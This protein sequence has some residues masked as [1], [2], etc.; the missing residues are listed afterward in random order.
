M[1]PATPSRTLPK[2]NFQHSLASASA[3]GPVAAPAAADINESTPRWDQDAV[4]KARD[5]PSFSHPDHVIPPPSYDGVENLVVVCC[6]AIFHPDVLDPSF[7]LNS[8]HNE[9]N[10]YLAPFQES[11]AETGKPGEHET[12]L[13]HMSAGVET[14]TIGPWADSSVLVFSGGVTKAAL[15]PLSEAR[16]Y[17]HAALAEAMVNGYRDGGPVK[18]LF[19]QGRILLEEQATD[20]FQ[21]LLFS[22]LLFRQTTGFYPKQIRIITHAFKSKRF[23][24]LHAQAIRWPVDRVRVEGIDPIM[25]SAEYGDTLGGEQRFGYALW[26]GDPLGTGEILSMK[27]KQRGWVDEASQ[28]L[29]TGLEES[30]QELINGR[31]TESLPWIE[32]E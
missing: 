29:A 4:D 10:W 5:S 14:L 12:F 23:L 6:H 3:H 13:A 21:N 7:P 26:L 31:I 25:S 22:I 30:V 11:N 1:A 8:P 27:R 28:Q 19:D 2:S 17:Y 32:A 24:D 15:T 18:T 16:S 9:S 20:S